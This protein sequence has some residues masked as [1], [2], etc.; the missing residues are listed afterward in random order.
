MVKVKKLYEKRWKEYR[1]LRL[2]AL[3]SDSIAFGS[4]YEEEA[5]MT[6]DEWKSSVRPGA[7]GKAKL[8][9]ITLGYGQLLARSNKIIPGPVIIRIGNAG[10]IEHILVVEEQECVAAVDG[11]DVLA[12]PLK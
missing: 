8:L 2:K 11:G 3:K 7:N 4:S 10:F 9:I 1:D 12:I 5:I 6:E